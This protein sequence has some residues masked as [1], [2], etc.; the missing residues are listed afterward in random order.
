MF[1]E[2]HLVIE[3]SCISVV[4]SSNSNY[5]STFL[6][7]MIVKEIHLA[8]LLPT[9]IRQY[10]IELVSKLVNV[11]RANVSVF[12][13]HL[14]NLLL[15]SKHINFVVALFCFQDLQIRDVI[16]WS[17]FILAK[18]QQTTSYW[19]S[20]GVCDGILAVLLTLR[21]WKVH[22]FVEI[23]VLLVLSLRRKL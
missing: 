12:S 7:P 13:L 20:L 8:S 21:K 6:T 11:I 14:K 17:E 4:Q 23:N 19:M 1:L 3:N 2:L 10:N 5:P 22:F 9:R 16:F 18:F 15:C